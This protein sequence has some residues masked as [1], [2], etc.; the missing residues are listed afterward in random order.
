MDFANG[1]DATNTYTLDHELNVLG[2]TNGL[3]DVID[4]THTRTDDIN[5]T[6]ISAANSQVFAYTAANRLQTA[7]GPWGSKTYTYDG[8]GNRTEE[9]TTPSGGS[10]TIDTYGY[11][12]GNNRITDITR[13]AQTVRSFG[14]DAAGNMTS[15]NRLLFCPPPAG[16]STYACTYNNANRL[17]CWRRAKQTCRRHAT[18][19]RRSPMRA[20]SRARTPKLPCPPSAGRRPPA[21]HAGDH[22]LGVVHFGGTPP[23]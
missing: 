9:R 2:L 10:E 22:Q 4:R 3:T 12:A 21:D 20:T 1:L 16:R 7:T 15:D 19:A 14:Y 11:P 13:G 5:L 8:V 18:R 17:S 6:N 23:A